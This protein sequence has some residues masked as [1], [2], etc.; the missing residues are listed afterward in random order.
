MRLEIKHLKGNVTNNSWKEIQIPNGDSWELLYGHVI[1]HSDKLVIGPRQLGIKITDPV[2]GELFDM[3]AGFPQHSGRSYH[4]ALM[5][6]SYRDKQVYSNS[7]VICIPQKFLI[8]E[9]TT[10]GFGDFNNINPDSDTLDYSLIFEVDK[11]Y[12][13]T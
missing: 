8:N 9:S 13:A 7:A 5:P 10:I 2:D 3:H 4:Y 12:V 6:G 11:A 1:I